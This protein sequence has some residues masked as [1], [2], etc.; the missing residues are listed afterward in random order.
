MDH[1]RMVVYKET[2]GMKRESGSKRLG[3]WMAEQISI[4]EVAG[5]EP[6]LVT[7]LGLCDS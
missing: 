1:V 3:L 5:T 7:A 6:V 2:K 4:R